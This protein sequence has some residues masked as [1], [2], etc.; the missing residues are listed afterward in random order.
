MKKNN[1]LKLSCIGLSILCIIVFVCLSLIMSGKTSDSIVEV[2]KIYLSE[3][4]LQFQQKFTSII[5]LRLQQVDSTILMTPPEQT[6][7]SDELIQELRNNAEV[8]D[9]QYLGFYSENGELVDI[10][11]D[12]ITFNGKDDI[13]ASLK[14]NGTI[15]S[16]GTDKNR[17][18]VLILGRKASYPMGNGKTSVALIAGITMDYIDKALYLNSDESISY[19]HIIDSDGVFIIKNADAVRDNYYERIE[20]NFG[21]NSEQYAKNLRQAISQRQDYV[22]YIKITGENRLVYCSPLSENADWYLITVIPYGA[23][24]APLYKLDRVRFLTMIISILILLAPIFFIF[25]YYR[26]ETIAQMNEL[27]KAK[28][29]AVH[30]NNAKSEFLSNMSHDIRTPMNAIIGMT[31]IAQKNIKNPE[32]VGE[33]LKKINLSSK[34]LLGLINDILD[35]S[36]IESGKMTLN[37]QP[38]SLKESMDDIVNIMQPQIKEHN[39]F[40]DIFIQDIPFENVEC[41]EVRLNEVLIN[42]LSNAT[43]FTPEG[44]RIDVYLNQESSPLGDEYIRTL[45]TIADT[46]IGMSREFQKKLFSAFERENTEL[47]QK[48]TGTGL[49][50]AISH[51]IIEMMGGDIS[52]ESEQGK[53]TTFYITLDLKK[54]KDQHEN[55]ELPSWNILVVDD[56]EALC[57]SAASNLEDLGAHAEWTTDGMDAQKK[58]LERHK[59]NNDYDFVL[60]DWKMPTMSGIQTIREIRKEIGH[61]VPIVLISAYDWNEIALEVSESDIE[62][63]IAKPLFKSTLYYRLKQFADGETHT[64]PHVQAKTVKFSGKRI[65]L[66]E[67]IDINWEVANELL[68]YLDLTLERAVNGQDCVDKFSASENGYYDAILMDI[69]MPVMSGYDATKAIRALDREDKQLPIIAM[70]ADAFSDDAK[71]CLEAGMDAHLAKPLNMKECVRVLQRFLD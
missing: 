39:Q 50:M 51:K 57:S 28:Q 40:F 66:A 55:M 46:G 68:G 69:R 47:I 23:F 2:G 60:I 63:F 4:N 52:V 33:C 10:Y 7:Y 21:K 64:E 29:E 26:K 3:M 22:M 24:D 19:S 70:T 30:A 35:M 16:W 43:K 25:I 44:G 12:S 62:G 48:T 31:E 27:D 61:E 32:R 5:N 34:H 71:Q 11:G 54:A 65:L 8:K 36:K 14:D 13:M 45:I 42:V 18:K 41:D 67:D 56:N 9:F 15:I 1:V 6:E 37:I 59:Q 53:G 49:G 17:E 58:I 38:V 20:A